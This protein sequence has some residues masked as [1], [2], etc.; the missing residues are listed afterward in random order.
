[1][2]NSIMQ[3]DKT[4]CALCG[5]VANGDPLDK[6][7]IFGAYNRKWSEK[8]GLTVYLHHNK[9]HIFGKDAV[10]QNRGTD[11]MLKTAAQIKAM[12]YYGWTVEDFRAIF[13]KSYI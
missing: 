10:H 7:H 3:A 9:C 1:M 2:T 12:Q 13:G 4:H 8:Y 5:Q 6:H 11:E